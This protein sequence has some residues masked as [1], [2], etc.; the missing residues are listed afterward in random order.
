MS[1][2]DIYSDAS[3]L[4]NGIKRGTI[5]S[6]E[7]LEQM[8]KRIEDKNPQ[9]NAVVSMDLEQARQQADAAD[10]AVAAGEPLGQWH[11]LPMTVKDTWEVNGLSCTAGAPEYR[12]Y[13]SKRSAIAVKRLQDEGAI[14]FGKT[15][16]PYLAADIQSFNEL[17]GTSNN[18]WDHQ[19]TPGGSSGGAAAALA[20]GFTPLEFG[21]DLAGSIR[22]PAHFCGVYG[23]KP[24]HG[25]ISLQG[26]V[27]GPP[28]TLS[29]PSLV[30][31]GPMARS[32]NDLDKMLT[33]LC[34]ATD[35]PYVDIKLPRPGKKSLADFK[36]LSWF[37]DTD[38]PIESGLSDSYKAL[39]EVLVNQGVDVVERSEHEMSLKPIYTDY[40]KSLGAL[41]GSAQPLLNRV[42]MALAGHLTPIMSKFLGSSPDFKHVL[43]AANISFSK[44]GVLEEHRAQLKQ[45]F[46]SVFDDYDVILM[47]TTVGAAIHHN[48]DLTLDRRKIRI[49]GHERP[50][51]DLFSWISLA[52]L[53][54]LPATSAPI[55]T[56]SHGLPAN[57]QI[58]GAP[59]QDRMTIQFAKLLA[60][61]L[62]GFERPPGY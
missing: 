42:L 9:I 62:G 50:Y 41:M 61:Q 46:L 30:V 36:V 10:A 12:H 32:A 21:S 48:Q 4:V 2:I 54:D 17:H 23:H 11:G 26:H 47:P 56:V 58:V 39:K 15:N 34:G 60:K 53:F 27:P 37:S 25:I 49:D 1:D 6:R 20:A 45:K 22:I 31:A 29:E 5:S 55:G 57:V 44:H 59:Y 40:L 33:T 52:T 18:P 24:T 13:K 43:Q 35:A 28:G 38:Y 51:T 7:L 19:R 3:T 16:T 8:V 14:I